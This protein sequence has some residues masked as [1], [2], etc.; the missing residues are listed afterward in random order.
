M[1]K[2]WRCTCLQQPAP[3]RLHP[4][5]AKGSGYQRRMPPLGSRNQPSNLALLVNHARPPCLQ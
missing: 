4:P 2:H 3:L 1:A 5:A